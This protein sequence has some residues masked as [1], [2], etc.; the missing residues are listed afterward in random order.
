MDTIYSQLT[1]SL[2]HI[3]IIFGI[4]TLIV[5]LIFSAGVA[6][7]IGNLNS[8]GIPPQF[9]PGFAWVIA[10]IALGVWGALI[11]WLMHHSSLARK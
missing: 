4:L 2:S 5:N 3:S 11:Y 6:K 10:T 1:N 7:D 9:V 8:R